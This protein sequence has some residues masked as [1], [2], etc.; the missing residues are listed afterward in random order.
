MGWIGRCISCAVFSLPSL[1]GYSMYPD[2]D[3]DREVGWLDWLM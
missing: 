1:K 2:L 3:L